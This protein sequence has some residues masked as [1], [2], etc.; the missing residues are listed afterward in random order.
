MSTI[1]HPPVSGEAGQTLDMFLDSLTPTVGKF[2]RTVNPSVYNV[3]TLLLVSK[4]KPLVDRSDD[5]FF[6]EQSPIQH[7]VCYPALFGALCTSGVSF[8]EILY[9]QAYPLMECFSFDADPVCKRLGEL[10][11][12][13]GK[14]QALTAPV[15]ATVC[16]IERIAL[17]ATPNRPPQYKCKWLVRIQ[18]GEHYLSKGIKL[19]AGN[20]VVEGFDPAQAHTSF[21][22]K[23]Q[24]KVSLADAE[25]L[26]TFPTIKAAVQGQTLHTF[27]NWSTNDGQPPT[28]D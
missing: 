14:H 1:D 4:G 3:E 24:F 5:A 16:P 9:I 26:A 10:W 21:L 8:G 27:Y 18:S 7:R 22:T 15:V 2:I 11:L 12:L 25:T 20:Y 23:G 13:P 6:N 19:T 28:V 17:G